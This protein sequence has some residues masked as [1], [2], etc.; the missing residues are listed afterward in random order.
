[1]D[2]QNLRELEKNCR[3]VIGPGTPNPLRILIN[4]LL[5]LVVDRLTYSM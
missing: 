4:G 3:N 5:L 1:M 2:L